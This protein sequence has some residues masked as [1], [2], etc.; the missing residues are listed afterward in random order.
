MNAL[1]DALP[2]ATALMSAAA[3]AAHEH[4]DNPPWLLRDPDAKAV[5]DLF[6]PSPL[7]FQLAYPHEPVLAAARVSS[8]IRARFAQMVL[9]DAGFDQCVVLGA[10]LDTSVYRAADAPLRVWLVD[11]S[12]VLAWRADLFAQAGLTD[13]GMPV[14]LDLSGGMLLQSLVNAGL[15][16][17]RPTVVLGLGLSMYLNAE[18]NQALWTELAP[19]APESELVFDALLPDTEADEAGRAYAAAITAAAGQ[20]E[21]WQWRPGISQLREE[22]ACAGWQAEQHDEA[23]LVASGFWEANPGLRAMRLVRLVRARRA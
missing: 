18:Q 6:T 4:L 14:P 23:D 21:P 2:S 3:R 1:N 15:E 20:R 13:A 19:L 5:C 12:E 22:L 7:S 17:A 16:V 9:S 10:G 8:V 11:R